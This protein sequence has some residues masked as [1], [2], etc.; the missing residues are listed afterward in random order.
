MN[1]SYRC[2]LAFS[3]ME[4]ASVENLLNVPTRMLTA[5]GHSAT[6]NGHTCMAV[7]T[8][9]MRC[10]RDDEWRPRRHSA[11][12]SLT[13]TRPLLI[14]M[15]SARMSALTSWWRTWTSGRTAGLA[16]SSSGLG[17]S[18]VCASF[19]RGTSSWKNWMTLRGYSSSPS[20][21]LPIWT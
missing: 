8:H 9:E 4:W 7:T 14:L 11:P 19:E 18:T 21:P 12:S 10:P 1:I 16:S 3:D 5:S 20:R 15:F 17:I 2:R 6:H 13:S